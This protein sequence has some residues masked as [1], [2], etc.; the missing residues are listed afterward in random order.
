MGKVMMSRKVIWGYLQ[1]LLIKPDRRFPA[2]LAASAGRCFLGI[3][4]KQQQLNVARASRDSIVYRCPVRPEQFRIRG[5]INCCDLF[6]S[7]RYAHLL[8]QRQSLRQSLS[9]L[10]GFDG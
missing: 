9:P 5:F 8:R 4:S 2:M 10:S 7:D 6:L 1:S 3:T